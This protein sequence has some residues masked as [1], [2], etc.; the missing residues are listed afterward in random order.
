MGQQDILEYLEDNPKKW[1]GSRELSSELDIS[2]GSIT[3]SLKKL[4]KADLI[5][6]KKTG[7]RNAFLYALKKN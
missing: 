2:I 7:L 6:Y 3:M 5:K 1:F 4:R